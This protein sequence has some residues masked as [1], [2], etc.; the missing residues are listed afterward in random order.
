MDRAV[1]ETLTI[2]DAAVPPVSGTGFGVTVHAAPEGAPVQA[3]IT[4]PVKP[5][6]G[7]ICKLY[8]AACPAVTVADC[9]LDALVN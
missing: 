8:A 6:P 4:L 5:E 7:V 9:A 3:H 2:N 1:V